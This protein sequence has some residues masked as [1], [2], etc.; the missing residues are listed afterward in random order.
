ME[1]RDDN[2]VQK[3]NDDARVKRARQTDRIP[4][5]LPGQGLRNNTLLP[6]HHSLI[7]LCGL[8]SIFTP[9]STM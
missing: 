2:P 1:T 6:P 7:L 3:K 8:M 5:S 4:V 9:T